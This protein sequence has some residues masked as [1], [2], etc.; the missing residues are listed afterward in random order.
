MASRERERESSDNSVE[1]DVWPELGEIILIVMSYNGLFGTQL[2]L[3]G[4]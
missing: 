4:N 3:S 2:T 1:E